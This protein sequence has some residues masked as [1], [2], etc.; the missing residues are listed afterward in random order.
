M[1]GVADGYE[2]GARSNRG[3]VGCLSGRGWYEISVGGGDVLTLL[4]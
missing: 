1:N 4:G 2:K 3:F